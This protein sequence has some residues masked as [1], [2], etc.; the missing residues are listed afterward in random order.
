MPVTIEI[1][2]ESADRLVV[3]A[4]KQSIKGLEEDLV[5]LEDKQTLHPHEVQDYMDFFA[6]LEALTTAHNYFTAPSE[7]L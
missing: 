4:L 1:A 2:D 3:A 5:R 7:H 6:N